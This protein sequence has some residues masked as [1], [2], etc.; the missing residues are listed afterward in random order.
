MDA[1]LTQA[2]KHSRRKQPGRIIRHPCSTLFAGSVPEF[3]GGDS[4]DP[5][6]I[7]APPPLFWDTDET[8]PHPAAENHP[9]QYGEPGVLPLSPTHGVVRRA[10]SVPQRKDPRTPLAKPEEDHFSSSLFVYRPFHLPLL[11]PP[12]P[13]WLARR[14]NNVWFF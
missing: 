12:V 6:D 10:S 8:P 4:P 9:T 7:I 2:R 1:A 13:L 14:Y 5:A 11:S 3:L